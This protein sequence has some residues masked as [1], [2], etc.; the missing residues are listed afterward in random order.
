MKI[1]LKRKTSTWFL[2]SKLNNFFT[3]L[4]IKEAKNTVVYKY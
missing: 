3:D 4:L 2:Y 1:S